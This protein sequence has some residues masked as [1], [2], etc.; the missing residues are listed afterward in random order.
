M[1][2]IIQF[3]VIVED[4]MEIENT[5]IKKEFDSFK[6]K[7]RP[8]IDHEKMLEFEIAGQSDVNINPNGKLLYSKH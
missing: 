8:E 6:Q 7:M 3:I 4:Y 5:A 2:L 1:H